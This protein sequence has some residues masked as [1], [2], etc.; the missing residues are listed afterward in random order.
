M[1]TATRIVIVTLGVLVALGGLGYWGL[2]VMPRPFEPYPTTSPQPRTT[3]FPSDLP[4]P[5]A[6]FF[7][8]ALGGRVPVI[9]S[10]II[11]GRGY[12]RLKGV[13]L[14]TR[15]R[16]T[17]DAGQGYRH[18]MESTLF[19]RPLF[20]VNEWFLGGKGRLE[21][22][23]GVIGDDPKTNSAGNLG[24]WGE[25]LFL[26]AIFL[27]DPRV[28]WEPIDE[29]H[30]RLIVPSGE[31]TDE[32]TVAFDA[33]TGMLQSMDAMRWREPTSTAKTGWNL[34]VLE[35]GRKEGML[36]PV[37]WAVTWADEGVPWFAGEVEEVVYNVDVT[38]YIRASGP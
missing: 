27:T 31:A 32:F 3:E 20:R 33:E 30:A 19:G 11:S 4:A 21:L 13:R 23:G 16:F 26:P 34:K 14:P 29:T 2:Q 35:W 24:L 9:E 10:A 1:H 37:R 22:P 18:Y 12:V 28:G 5:V 7:Q 17:H 8:Q 38:D 36:L 15:Y 6:R 25:S